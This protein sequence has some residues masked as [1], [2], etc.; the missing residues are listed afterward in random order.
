M[1][2]AEPDVEV[3]DGS[4]KKGAK[5]FKAKCA[6]CHTIEKNGND[7]Q[8]PNLFGLFGREAGAKEGFAYSEAN[9]SSGIT[10][11]DKHLLVYLKNP[12]A[13]IPGTKMVFAGLKKEKEQGDLI[14]YMKKF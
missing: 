3:P 5:L 12:K 8:G 11:S 2:K 1:V 6:Q 4:E 14:A 13:Y 9:K 10:W 7:K